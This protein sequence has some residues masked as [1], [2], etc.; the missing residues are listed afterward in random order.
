MA[1]LSD[2]RFDGHEICV[3]LIVALPAVTATEVIA[4]FENAMGRTS[5]DLFEQ[6]C[7][8]HPGLYLPGQLRTSERQRKR[9]RAAKADA[10]IL[11]A[12]AVA[13]E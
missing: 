3:P 4:L 11:G 5:R 10:L 1:P 8:D 13:P 7:A 12:S 9:W 2:Q 6:L